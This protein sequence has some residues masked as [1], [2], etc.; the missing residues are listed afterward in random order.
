M[1]C[2]CTRTSRAAQASLRVPAPG[3]ARDTRLALPAASQRRG[4][5]TFVAALLARFRQSSRAPRPTRQVRPAPSKAMGC[6]EPVSAIISCVSGA[7]ETAQG[8]SIF[9]TA[10][11]IATANVFGPTK[12]N[13]LGSSSA[14]GNGPSRVPIQASLPTTVEISPDGVIF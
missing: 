12:L 9:T 2:P 8:S 6:A 1:I 13:P 10:A 5:H 14:P 11:G 7:C 4:A 3:D